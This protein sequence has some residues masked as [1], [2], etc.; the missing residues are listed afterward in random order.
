MSFY[1]RLSN[2]WDIA[3]TSFKVLKAHKVLII[4]P[5]LSCLSMLLVIASFFTAVMSGLGWDFRLLQ[6][7]S[8]FQIY[9]LLFCFYIVNYFV[10]VFFNMAI[11]HCA[12]LHFDGEEVTVA[13]GLRFSVSRLGT[14]VSWAVFA[15]TVGMILKI[16]QDNLGWIGKII[17]SI[18]GFV[19][20]AATFFVVPVLAYEDL[21]PIEAVKRS[22]QVMKDKWGESIGANFS[23]GFLS[24]C[25]MILLGIICTIVCVLFN[26]IPVLA[27]MG[28]F[29]LGTI[30]IFIISSALHSIFISAVYNSIT[31]NQNTPFDQNIIDT[32]FVPKK[33]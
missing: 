33:K 18:V 30:T 10:I 29:L 15:A 12:R 28:V 1:Q 17:I 7:E 22:A 13:K 4:F 25:A 26:T 2:G 11:M 3:E 21:G 14:I 6:S 24:F 31:G 27:G 8:R 9:A 19:W 16:A 5:I 32:L 23:I 20:S